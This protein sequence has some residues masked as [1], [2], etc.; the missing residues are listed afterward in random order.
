MMPLVACTCHGE[1]QARCGRDVGE[2]W[3]RCGR[4]IGKIWGDI[5]EI[6][7]D[8]RSLGAEAEAERDMGRF[9]GDI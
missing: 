5:G 2:I 8:L 4:D 9:R 1:I 6:E 3:A 7:E